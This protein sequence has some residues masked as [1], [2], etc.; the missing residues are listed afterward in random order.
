MSGI[1]PDR[2]HPINTDDLSPGMDMFDYFAAHAMSALIVRG[3]MAQVGVAMGLDPKA[4]DTAIKLNRT[5]CI[6]AW[7]I[8]KMM[9]ETKKEVLG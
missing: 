1:S 8:T 3:H 2:V 7:N 9:L 4:S 6:T 5:T